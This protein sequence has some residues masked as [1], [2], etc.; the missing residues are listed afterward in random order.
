MDS[1]AK[2][3]KILIMSLSMVEATIHIQELD[4]AQ[5]SIPTL[6]LKISMVP[7]V[8]LSRIKKTKIRRIEAT[9]SVVPRNNYQNLQVDI[10]CD[11]SAL[12]VC[13]DNACDAARDDA[14]NYGCDVA[15]NAAY[16]N[17]CDVAY[18]DA[19]VL[20]DVAYDNASDATCDVAYDN[21]A[22]MCSM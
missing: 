6:Y 10:H 11:T 12:N 17:E 4:S 13:C 8:W 15:H 19:C 7:P 16:Y 9:S 3:A 22:M 20:C 14:Y 1:S 18:D 21:G 2:L 5:M